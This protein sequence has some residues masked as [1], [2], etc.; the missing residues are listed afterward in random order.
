MARYRV[1]NAYLSEEEYAEHQKKND[2]PFV[3]GFFVIVF[4][5]LSY[6]SNIYLKA[7]Y[8]SSFSSEIRVVLSLVPGFFIGIIMFIFR[9]FISMPICLSVLG[10]IL[11]LLWKI[12]FYFLA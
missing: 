2:N 9:R 3:F 6:Q 1:G 5:V 4:L 10:V 8:A 12:T 7:H 11:Y